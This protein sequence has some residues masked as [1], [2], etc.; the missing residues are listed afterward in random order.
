MLMRRKS[1]MKR[2]NGQRFFG[3]WLQVAPVGGSPP[4]VEKKEVTKGIKI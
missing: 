1:R 2:G 3:G 4:K